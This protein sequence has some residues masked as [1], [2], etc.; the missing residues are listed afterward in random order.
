MGSDLLSEKAATVAI[1]TRKHPAIRL[2]F[3]AICPLREKELNGRKKDRRGEE[4]RGE[5]KMA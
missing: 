4:G 1:R 5:M 2:V 3:D